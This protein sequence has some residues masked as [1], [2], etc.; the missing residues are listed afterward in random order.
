MAFEKIKNAVSKGESS[1]GEAQPRSRRSGRAA[2]DAGGADHTAGAVATEG[3]SAGPGHP[4]RDRGGHRGARDRRRPAGGLPDHGARHPADR[5]RPLAQ[6]RQPRADPVAGPPPPREDQP[7]RPRAHPGARRA[8]PRRGRPRGVRRHRRRRGD[9]PGG[10]PPERRHHAGLRAVLDGPGLPRLGGPGPRHPRLRHPLL[11]RRRQL[12]PR[13]QQHPGLLHPGRHQ[14]PRR[15]PRRQT[16]P[17]PRD[18]AGTERTRHFLG[19]RVAAH[20]STGP[21]HVEHVRPRAAPLVPHHGGLRRPHLPARQRRGPDL[22][23][24]VPLEAQAG[25]ALG[26]LGGGPAHQRSGPGLPPA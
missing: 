17:G 24:E 14:V 9:L 18:P 22:P 25:R 3:G 4:H 1:T 11:H 8:R 26:D 19:L 15:D 16:A 13:R 10:I 12:R 2:A 6:G 7:L 5:H 20:R 21:H 23:G